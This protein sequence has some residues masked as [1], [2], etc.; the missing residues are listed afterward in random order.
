MKTQGSQNSNPTSSPTRALPVDLNNSD[1]LL[2]FMDRLPVP[3]DC[4][5][6]F[7][8]VEDDY[9]GAKASELYRRL[10]ARG[11]SIPVLTVSVQ[12]RFAGVVGTS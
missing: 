7:V 12:A 9:T 8:I 10:Q 5:N 1:A 4:G 2:E 6:D 3:G 11:W